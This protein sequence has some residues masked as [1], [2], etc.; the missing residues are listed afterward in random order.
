[1]TERLRREETDTQKI[2]C[3]GSA[4]AILL[5]VVIMES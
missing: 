2:L 3:G 5:V 1:M 4:L